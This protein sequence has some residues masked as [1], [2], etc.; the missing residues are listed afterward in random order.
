MRTDGTTHG[1]A[2]EAERAGA[3]ADPP[4]APESVR[5]ALVPR[6]ADPGERARTARPHPD[7]GWRGSVRRRREALRANPKRNHLYRMVVGAVGTVVVVLGLVLVPLPGPGW[8]VVFLGL[9]VLG[10][11]FS[12][13]RR[14][15]AFG[16][17]QLHRWVRWVERRSWRT[18]IALGGGTGAVVLLAVWGWFAW[19]GVPSWSPEVVTAQLQRVPGVR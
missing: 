12:S 1:G 10:S 14:L 5:S 13:A 18:R 3:P 9:A 17:R 2:H 19:Q 15:N 8:L 7:H 11:E 4:A 6:P 16:Q